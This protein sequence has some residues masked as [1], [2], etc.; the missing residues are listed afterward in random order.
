MG[1]NSRG[2]HFKGSNLVQR[3]TE[4]SQNQRCS[5]LDLGEWGPGERESALG[6]TETTVGKFNSGTWHHLI[7]RNGDGPSIGQGLKVYRRSAALQIS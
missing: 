3:V 2:L 4:I 6:K 5:C 7:E 1:V